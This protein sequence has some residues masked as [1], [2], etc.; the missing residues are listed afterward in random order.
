MNAT[1]SELSDLSVKFSKKSDSFNAT[2]K[3]TNK[4]LAKLN[5]SVEVWIGMLEHDPYF[6]EEIDEEHRYPLRDE[7]LLG[8]SKVDDEWQLATKLQ[9][10]GTDPIGRQFAEVVQGFSPRPLLNA[11][12]TVRIE[13]AKYIPELF[14]M[15]SCAKSGEGNGCD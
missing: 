4:N 14:S 15:N 11:S 7:I 6:N 12:R 5:L 3:S 8:Y 13:A 10:M 1:I 2:I 9:T